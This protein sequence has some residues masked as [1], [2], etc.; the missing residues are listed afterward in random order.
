VDSVLSVG[1]SMGMSGY[2]TPLIVVQRRATILESFFLDAPSVFAP[3]SVGGLTPEDFVVV[4]N[5]EIVISSVF[6]EENCSMLARYSHLIDDA[7]RAAVLRTK[8]PA[9]VPEP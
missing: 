4:I 8:T 1:G 5:G 3:V 2:L 9:K 6:H 7:R